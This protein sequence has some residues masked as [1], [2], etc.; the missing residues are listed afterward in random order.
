MSEYVTPITPAHNSLQPYSLILPARIPVLLE[1]GELG[2]ILSG[3]GMVIQP[4][5]GLLIAPACEESISKK[6]IHFKN[7]QSFFIA[8]AFN[9]FGISSI[10]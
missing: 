2:K 3:N 9:S 6:P 8:S 7:Y 1:C 10:A 4:M 5:P